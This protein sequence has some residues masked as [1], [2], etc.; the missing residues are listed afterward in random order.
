MTTCIGPIPVRQS[1]QT[2]L[3]LGPFVDATDGVTHETG[4]SLDSASDLFKAGSA[5][6]V[7]ISGNTWAHVANGYYSLVLTSSN[8]DTCGPALMKFYAPGTYEGVVVTLV[9]HPPVVY[10]S[11]FA[12]TDTLE[13]DAVAISGDATAADNLEAGLEAVVEFTVQAASSTTVVTTNLSETTDDHYNGRSAYF[14][15]GALAGQRADI[16]DYSGSTKNLTVSTL[17]EAPQNGDKGVIE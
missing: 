12:G 15:T 13:V 9:V 3:M 4:V 14:R 17:T 6:A 7:D 11:L 1:T 16:T 8:L 10:D 2:T 5:S